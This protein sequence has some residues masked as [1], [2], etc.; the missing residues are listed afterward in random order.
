[1]FI[2]E[3]KFELGETCYT[4]YR[5]PIHYK[6]PICEG[7]GKFSYNGYEIWCKNCS[8]SGKLHN[9]HQTVAESCQV[10]ILGIKASVNSDNE[11]TVSYRVRP[12][13]QLVSVK[14]RA[15]SLLFKTAEECEANCQEMNQKSPQNVAD[16]IL[17]SPAE[18][19]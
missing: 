9:A 7:A 2:I 3:N 14:K 16:T 1:M 11:I 17:D 4:H 6:C 18:K 13:D 10:K 15:E 5:K 12:I 19:G 8:G